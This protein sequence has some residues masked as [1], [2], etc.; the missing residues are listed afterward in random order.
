MMKI[1]DLIIK[2]SPFACCY[3]AS[4]RPQDFSHCYGSNLGYGALKILLRN[5]RKCRL[6]NR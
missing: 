5:L 4:K 2:L 1:S 3:K 6:K